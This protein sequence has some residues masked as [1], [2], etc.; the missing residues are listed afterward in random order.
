MKEALAVIGAVAVLAFIG[1]HLPEEPTAAERH[2]MERA[3]IAELEVRTAELEAEAA[4]TRAQRPWRSTAVTVL[5]WIAV[6]AAFVLVGVLVYSVWSRK[7]YT[8]PRSDGRLPIRLKAVPPQDAIAAAQGLQAR[9]LAVA[10]NTGVPQSVSLSNHYAPSFRNQ[11][12]IQGVEGD[13]ALPPAAA[14]AFAQMPLQVE[15]VVLGHDG[16]DLVTRPWDLLQSLAVGGLSGSGK[17]FTAVSLVLQALH[18][19]HRVAI[20]DPHAADEQSLTARLAPVHG[21]LWRPVAVRQP[22]AAKMLD[23]VEQL[24]TDRGTGDDMDRTPT[25]LIVDEFTRF[26]RGPSADTV[27]SILE[28]VVAEGRKL[29]VRAVVLGQRWSA[30]RSGGTD[31]RDIIPNVLLHTMRREDAR[32]LSGWPIDDLPDT[33]KLP[34]GECYLLNGDGDPVKVAQPRISAVDVAQFAMAHNPAVSAGQASGQGS[35][36]SMG[37]VRA[38]AAAADFGPGSGHGSGHDD[39]DETAEFRAK[40]FAQYQAGR[41]RAEIIDYL[42]GNAARSSGTWKRVQRLVDGIC[43]H[44]MRRRAAEPDEWRPEPRNRDGSPVDG[45]DGPGGIS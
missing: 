33:S 36:Q 19:G 12:D 1:T 11:Q 27:S 6:A 28:G 41:S 17:T 15:S 42:S 7:D 10:S 44:E 5:I 37:Q 25:T 3:R 39:S 29:G 21:M 23:D 30:S 40:V 26:M 2:A 32:M 9:D 38:S 4:T 35:G 8:V 20:I 18:A 31:L 45:I 16:S 14:P 24:I 43:D 34:P 13:V 22:E